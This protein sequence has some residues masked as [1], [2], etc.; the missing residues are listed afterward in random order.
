MV[1]KNKWNNFRHNLCQ[2][3]EKKLCYHQIG[4][5]L[6]LAFFNKIIIP[7]DKWE[8]KF[9]LPLISDWSLQEFQSELAC[10]MEEQVIKED[11]YT[12][13]KTINNIKK[14]QH[15]NSCYLQYHPTFIKNEIKAEE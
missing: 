5:N 15:K 8:I 6:N 2:N 14:E 3:I 4:R 7:K 12:D 10:N 9:F 11:K 1:H 13:C